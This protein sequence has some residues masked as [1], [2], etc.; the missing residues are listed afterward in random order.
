M[1][2]DEPR[3]SRPT[4]P[5]IAVWWLC[6]VAVYLLFVGNLTWQET[7]AAIL[8]AAAAVALSLVAL[9]QTYEVVGAAAPALWRV[10]VILRLFLHES[11]AVLRWLGHRALGRRRPPSGGFVA[12]RLEDIDAMDATR[13]ASITIEASLAPNTYVVGVLEDDALLLLH[14]LVRTPDPKSSFPRWAK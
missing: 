6:Y 1:G 2:G 11:W 9:A 5:R 12:V 4:A 14:Q 10:R 3:R 13:D 7:V 8:I